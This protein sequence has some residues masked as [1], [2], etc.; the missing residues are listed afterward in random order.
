MNFSSPRRCALI[1]FLAVAVLAAQPARAADRSEIPEKYTWNLADLYATEADWRKAL[2]DLEKRI[3]GTAAFQGKLG[4]SPSAFA[5]ALSTIM[6]VGR[7]LSRV[8]TYASQL[9]DTDT[10]VSRSQEMQQATQKVSV[11]FSSAVSYLR[12]EILAMGADRVRDFIRR[13]PRLEDYTPYLENI[14]R[15]GPHTLSPAE[16]K[17]AAEAGR[18]ASSPEEVYSIFSDAD[19]PYPVI[20][21]AG[22][23]V[24]LDPAAYTQYRASTDR[25]LRRQVFTTFWGAFQNYRRTFG[26]TLLGQVK[27]HIFNKDVHRFGSSL[28]ASLFPD[29]IPTQVYHQLIADVHANLPT[30]HRYLKLRQKMMGLDQLG[31]EDLYAPIV[32]DVEMTFTPEEAMDLTI[33]AFEPLGQEYVD[34]LRRGYSERWIDWL[35]SKGKRSGAY[36]TLTY[37]LHPYQLLNFT[38]GY[39][40]VSTLAH[41]SGHSMHSYLSSRHQPYIT[42]DYA[43]FVAEV[44]STLNE[45]L[46]FH[47]MLDEAKDDDSR[48]FLLGSYLDGLRTTLFRQTL[49]AEFEL[50]LHEL[51]EK[52]EPVSGDALNEVYLG[53]LKKYYGHD[54]NVVRIDDLYAVEWAYIP[55]FY[56]N[57]YV[58]Q[59]ATSLVAATSL[60]NGIWDERAGQSPS[61]AKRDLYLQLLSSGSAK[62]PIQLLRD[63]G[64]DMTT[65]APFAAAMREMNA[66]MDQIEEI[67]AKQ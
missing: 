19:M 30:L 2:E 35:P 1:V 43:T 32:K 63:A 39:E 26:T 11:D 57:F 44:A 24:R 51:A 59:Y 34:V 54:E 52:G 3:P 15:W 37:G 42:H 47:K 67:L 13:E 21:I 4:D 23:S 31:Y 38:G 18:M 7:D 10:Q 29:N 58:Y 46:L 16:E 14:L 20:V 66:V 48:L 40:D 50:R 12:P 8:S 17:I 60:A 65:P 5:D 61:T 25:A 62:E 22:D 64:V 36:S 41:E 28:E 53:L 33:E 55:H 45:N 56:Y 49:F 6:D 27:A 9:Y